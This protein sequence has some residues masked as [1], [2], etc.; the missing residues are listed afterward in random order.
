MDFVF[1]D[2]V[3][4]SYPAFALPLLERLHSWQHSP[5]RPCHRRPGTRFAVRENTSTGHARFLYSLSFLERLP[6]S[7]TNAFTNSCYSQE[8]GLPLLLLFSSRS[9]RLAPYCFS[10]F[11]P[12]THNYLAGIYNYFFTFRTITTVPHGLPLG[13]WYCTISFLSFE[14]AAKIDGLFGLPRTSI[15]PS[16]VTPAL[17]IQDFLKCLLCVCFLFFFCSDDRAMC[18]PDSSCLSFDL[19][20]F[21]YLLS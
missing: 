19:I 9:D 8:S 11:L 14:C 20:P 6:S 16:L 2:D 7:D 21:V 13:G 4:S 12:G 3:S 18:F 15:M 10:T 1:F 5:Q 17:N